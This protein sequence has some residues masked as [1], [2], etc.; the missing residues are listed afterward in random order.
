MFRPRAAIAFDLIIVKKKANAEHSNSHASITSFYKNVNIHF[1]AIFSLNI[2]LLFMM[3]R[4]K[5]KN[6]HNNEEKS[7]NDK[8]K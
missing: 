2:F 6:D 8:N 3:R 7:D 1:H 5:S 4:E